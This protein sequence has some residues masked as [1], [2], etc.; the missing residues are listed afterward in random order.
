MNTR[1]PSEASNLL[2]DLLDNPLEPGY[3]DAAQRR[4]EHGPRTGWRDHSARWSRAV[5]IALVGFLLTVAY[6]Q[7]VADQP[8]TSKA[9]ADLVDDVRGRRRANDALEKQ[10]EALRAE[11][12]RAGEAALAGNE[13][14]AVLRARAAAAGLGTVTGG[15][16]IVELTDATSV[17]DPV[18]GKAAAE[19]PG[20][21]LDR[22]L[23]DVAN[24]LWQLGAEAISINGHRLTATATI[25]AAGGA[26]LVDFRPV[27][28]PY[29]V[30]AIGPGSLGDRFGRSATA[31]RYR[32]YVKEYRMRFSV[33]KRTSMTLP[34]AA[35]PNLRYAHPPS[36][37]TPSRSAPPV[38]SGTGGN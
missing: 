34:A 8:K 31:G 21:V 1:Q 2:S 23:Q 7:V 20:L 35:E 14:A 10:A 26:I 17:V 3:A 19:N 13:D 12:A 16:A 15:G 9:R 33:R 25:R 5:T 27:T 11:V 22:D 4:A 29:K 37:P 36:A 30:S 38:P 24:A 28:S 32:R 6:Q 18:T